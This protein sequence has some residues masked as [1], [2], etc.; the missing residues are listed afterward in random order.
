[1][2]IHVTDFAVEQLKA[3]LKENATDAEAGL[4]L[5]VEKG[6]CAG[7]QYSMTLGS[8]VKNDEVIEKNGVKVYVDSES[9]P[10]LDG[11]TI[12]YKDELAGKGF[13]IS[14]PNAVRSCGCGTSFETPPGK[15]S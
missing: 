5:S 11:C 14:N 7:M 1:M 15:T 3:L 4:R 13:R 2:V 10:W 8:P 6:G 12:D 9:L